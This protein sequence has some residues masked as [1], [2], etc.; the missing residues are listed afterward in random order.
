MRRGQMSHLPVRPWSKI[1]TL[2]TRSGFAP[3]PGRLGSLRVERA[4]RSVKYDLQRDDAEE[5]SN[6]GHA[7]VFSS[8]AFSRRWHDCAG[9]RLVYLAKLITA[10]HGRPADHA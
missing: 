4:T 10:D 9:P 5:G 6:R 8:R 1:K 2:R 3:E 7:T